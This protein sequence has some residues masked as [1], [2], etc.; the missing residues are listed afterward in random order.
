MLLPELRAQVFAYAQQM[1]G[2]GLAHGSQ[3]NISALDRA[4]GLIAITPSAADYATMTADDIVVVDV[5]GTVVEGR[6]KPT[7]ELPLH[8]LFYRRRP[9]AGAVFHCHAPNVSGFA[10]ALRP[11]PIVL[12]ETACCV[13]RAIPCAPLMPSG[14]PAFAELMLDVIGQGNAAVMGQHGLVA[15]GTTLKR[16][17][18][19]AV[20]VE[21]S[22][23]AYLLARQIGVEPTP[24]PPEM[25]DELH[26]WW[27]TS[28]RQVA[29]G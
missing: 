13:G 6:W 22:A 11:V 23:R 8:T 12:L 10:A 2:D 28:Y 15:C 29:V 20:A 26:E 1:A 21:D 25:C 14:T 24:I 19:T 4:S 17:Y 9:D 7:I 3:G 18:G 5:E 16:A 27:Q